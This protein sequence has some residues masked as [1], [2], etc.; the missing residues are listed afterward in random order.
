MFEVRKNLDLRKMLVTPK[1]FLKSINAFNKKIGTVFPR[2]VVA[3]TILFLRLWVRQLFKGD[4]YSR[5]EN[6]CGNTVPIY[7]FFYFR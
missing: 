7:F 5:K 6:I 2:I 4:N 3:P 1:I